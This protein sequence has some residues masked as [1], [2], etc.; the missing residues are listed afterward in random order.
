VN[1][2]TLVGYLA[3]NTKQPDVFFTYA[4]G[5]PLCFYM[6]AVY[7][8]AIDAITTSAPPTR[9]TQ[10]LYSNAVIIA[11][12]GPAGH[13]FALLSA[14]NLTEALNQWTPEQTNTDGAGTFN[15]SLAPGT[16]RARFFRVVTQ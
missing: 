2:W 15:F 1:T 16:A 13:P 9:V 3:N 12:T 8:Q 4:S 6:D 5:N 10:I 7:F 14:T 11:G